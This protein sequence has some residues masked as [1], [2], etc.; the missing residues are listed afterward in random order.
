MAYGPFHTD[1]DDPERAVKFGELRALVRIVAGPTGTDAVAA[2]TAAMAD[3]SAAR[4][5]AARHAVEA[6]RP[7][8][9]RRVMATYAY[10]RREART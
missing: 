8:T 6:L 3:P 1:R 9:Y 4:I 10:L 2:L 7:K 5:D